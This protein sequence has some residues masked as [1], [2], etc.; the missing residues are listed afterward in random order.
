MTLDS[1][2]VLTNQKIEEDRQK[3]LAQLLTE[4]F[5][6]ATHLSNQRETD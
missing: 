5:G 4:R 3:L 1:K 6:T 2:T